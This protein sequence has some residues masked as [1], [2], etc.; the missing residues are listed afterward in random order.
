MNEYQY[1]ILDPGDWL[2]LAPHRAQVEW[3]AL[4]A[5]GAF[6]LR[7][8][9]PLVAEPEDLWRTLPFRRRGFADSGGRFRLEKGRVAVGRVPVGEWKPLTQWFQIR[10]PIAK[11][12]GQPEKLADFRPRRVAAGEQPLAMRIVDADH[13]RSWAVMA[14]LARL[15]PLSFA[16]SSDGRVCVRGTP[17]PPLPGTAWTLQGAIAVPAGLELPRGFHPEWLAEVI[18]LSEGDL[19]LW[20]EDGRTEVLPKSAFLPASRANV[21]ATAGANLIV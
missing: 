16:A 21:R 10:P 19:G 12:P 13:W 7:R 4:E 6:W 15:A 9:A 14:P 18:G 2:A 8:P 3:E 1:G 17:P 20:H 11:L 5:P